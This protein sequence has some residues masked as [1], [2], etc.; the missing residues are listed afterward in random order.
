[1]EN[2]FGKSTVDSVG[3]GGAGMGAGIGGSIPLPQKKT[4][5]DN[6]AFLLGFL[7]DV[8]RGKR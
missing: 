4:S 5:S 7:E 2:V 1:L 3:L 8:T 6:K